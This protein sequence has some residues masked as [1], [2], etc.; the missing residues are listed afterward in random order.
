MLER[1][2]DIAIHRVLNLFEAGDM[3]LLTFFSDDID[4]RIDHYKD[5]ADTQWQ[6][7]DSKAGLMKVLAQLGK[8]VFPNGTKITGLTSESLDDGWFITTFDQSFWYGLEGRDVDSRTYIVS[9]E[10]DGQVDYFRENVTT[11]TYRS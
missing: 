9:H 6:C 2:S 5:D 3:T 1:H 7:C 8:E 10:L 4:L 11:M